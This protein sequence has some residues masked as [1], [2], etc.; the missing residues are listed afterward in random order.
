MQRN[1]VSKPNQILTLITQIQK[2]FPKG[3]SKKKRSLVFINFLLIHND[4][5]ENIISDIKYQLE[6]CN[7]KLGVQYI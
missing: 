3:R 2:Y 6:R 7:I 1:F 5:T 4:D